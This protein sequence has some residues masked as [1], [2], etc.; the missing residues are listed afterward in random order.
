ML[1][2]A[3]QKHLLVNW[4][5]IGHVGAFQTD[6]FRTLRKGSKRQRKGANGCVRTCVVREKKRNGELRVLTKVNYRCGGKEG[7]GGTET[8]ESLTI[9]LRSPKNAGWCGV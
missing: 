8:N 6:G 1:W 5:H 2:R 4:V 9:V 7:D 3:Q